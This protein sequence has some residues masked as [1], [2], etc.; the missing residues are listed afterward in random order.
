MAKSIF[1]SYFDFFKFI[2]SLGLHGHQ[3]LYPM[4][5]IQMNVIFL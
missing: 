2:I 3:D 1:S 4:L 5:T